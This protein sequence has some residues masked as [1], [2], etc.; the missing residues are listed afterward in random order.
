MNFYAIKRTKDHIKYWKNRKADWKKS[1]LDTA[2]HP[3]RKLITGIL[4]DLKGWNAIFEIG[5]NAAPNM[6]ALLKRRPRTMVGACDVNE[7]AIKLANE[8]MI[9]G[10]F[11]AG[12]ADDVFMS[13]KSVDIVLSDMT[14]IY[15]SPRDI[16]RY[17]KELKRVGR[18]YVLL[19]EFHSESWWNR[20]A[21]KF[22]TGYYAHDYKRLLEKHG[23]YDI[24]YYKLKEEDWPGGNPQ[25]TFAYLIL[26]KIPYRN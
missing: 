13:D 11:M 16:N 17:I 6:V 3:H 23:F 21:L 9:G 14:L 19:C 24:C 26:A 18:Q 15:V 20:K 22:N 25:K 2:D 1:Y 10:N 7:E 12:S 4:C 5:C 8:T